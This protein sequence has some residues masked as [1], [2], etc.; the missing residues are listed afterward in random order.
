MVRSM[1]YKERESHLYLTMVVNDAHTSQIVSYVIDFTYHV[2]ESYCIC[3]QG[4]SQIVP[5][6]IDVLS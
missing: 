5:Y 1:A 4:P 3:E 2:G 6:V